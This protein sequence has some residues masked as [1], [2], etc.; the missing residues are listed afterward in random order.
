MALDANGGDPGPDR[1]A[2]LAAAA[3]LHEPL[4]FEAVHELG[5]VRADTVEPASQTPEGHRLGGPNQLIHRVELRHG[6]PHASERRLEALVQLLG[7]TEHGD[8]SAVIGSGPEGLIGIDSCTV[9]T[10]NYTPVM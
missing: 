4:G 7:S 2:V 8:Q 3:P 10:L 1:P 5:D 6:Q 9:H